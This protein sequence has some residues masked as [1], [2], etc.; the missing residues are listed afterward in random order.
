M[1]LIQY[2]LVSI[3]YFFSTDTIEFLEKYSEINKY[4]NN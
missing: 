1:R 2:L 4:R 3:F